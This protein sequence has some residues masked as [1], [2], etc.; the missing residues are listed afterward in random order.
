MSNT[1]GGA[2]PIFADVDKFDGTNW[3]AWN[4]LI[5][6]AAEVRGV[7]GYLDGTIPKPTGVPTITLTPPS[8]TAATATTATTPSPS[9]PTITTTAITQ[10]PSQQ[11]TGDT[12]WDSLTPSEAEW[13][14]RNAWAKGLLIFNTKNPIGLGITIAG[15][16][17]EAW[18]SY[19]DSYEVASE[20]ALLNAD[21]ELRSMK[22]DDSQDF[23]EHIANM[24]VKWAHANALGANVSDQSFKTIVLNS[25]PRSW[26]AVVA[27][28][29]CAQTSVEAISQLNVHWLRISRD[30][31]TGTKPIV[32][33]LQTSASNYRTKTRNQLICTNP[34]CNRRGH[35]IKNCYWT[36][37]GKEGQFL[38]GFGRRGGLR[39]TATNTRQGSFQ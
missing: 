16:A 2:P 35:A 17:A 19:I 14:I 28:L 25:L 36:G 1:G 39:G 24:R 10:I 5:R 6:I 22:Y 11:S 12:P 15:T 27:S 33:A 20:I 31:A 18:K 23:P 34:N 7:F 37:G 8:T 26:D 29:Y 13:K 3:V 21:L 9:P 32:T 4:G 38:P 30:R